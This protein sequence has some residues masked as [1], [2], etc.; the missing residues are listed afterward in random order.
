M[1]TAR[2]AHHAYKITLKG[3]SLRKWFAK[4]TGGSGLRWAGALT[5]S[6]QLGMVP[7]SSDH[8]KINPFPENTDNI[9]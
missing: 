8:V 6:R 3:E 2:Q 7:A 5:A 9:N 4:K 1:L